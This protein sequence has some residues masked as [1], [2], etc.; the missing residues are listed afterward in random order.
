M[1]VLPLLLTMT[2]A[3][4]ATAQNAPEAIACLKKYVEQVE[5]INGYSTTMAKKEYIVD[6]PNDEL[7]QLIATGPR[8]HVYMYINEGRTGLKNNGMTLT[9]NGT[10]VYD[11][12][13]GEAKGF[14]VFRNR[15][16]RAL[17][18]NKLKAND[19]HA[20]TG[21]IFTLNRAGF[22]FL[23]RIV[24][25]HLKD[26]QRSTV[27]GV[28]KAG[29]NCHLRYK[30]HST[31]FNKVLLKKDE[32]ITTLEE[33]YGV[34]AYQLHLAN[35]EIFKNLYAVFNRKEDVEILVPN[36]L[37]EFEVWLNPKTNLPDKFVIYDKDKT[38]GEYTF[39]N[40]QLNPIGTSSN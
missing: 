24:K 9:Y 29:E 14:A 4:K 21:E 34:L 36:F 28:T 2:L 31:T 16:A 37:I 25:Q 3:S 5:K 13:F 10:D 19:E 17:Y 40:T 1:T 7:V 30:P 6:P 27:G 22:Y 18:G 32:S 35:P 11:L 39:S 26:M 33:E 23:A 38:L 15:A 8:H 12:V 20:L